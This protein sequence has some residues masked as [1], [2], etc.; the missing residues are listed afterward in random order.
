MGTASRD[1]S[2]RI[3]I[4]RMH[5]EADGAGADAP[6]PG[7]YDSHRKEL[8]DVTSRWAKSRDRELLLEGRGRLNRLVLMP[9]ALASLTAIGTSWQT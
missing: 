7:T 5:S 8:A 3:Y 1:S 6:G 4:S 2:P 9:L